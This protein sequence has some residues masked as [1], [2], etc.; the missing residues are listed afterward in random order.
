MTSRS[1]RRTHPRLVR[2]IK[3]DHAKVDAAL[4]RELAEALDEPKM[5][6]LRRRVRGGERLDALMESWQRGRS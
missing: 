4:S 1:D 6:R 5:L 3:C 2:A